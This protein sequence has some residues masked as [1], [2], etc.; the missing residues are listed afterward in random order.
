M[1][2][3]VSR[4]LKRCSEETP[5]ASS[6]C[7]TLKRPKKETLVKSSLTY[8]KVG[9]AILQGKS[10]EALRLITEGSP[11]AW[12]EQDSH[13]I[14]LSICN[15]SNQE[16]IKTL[17]NKTDAHI[18]NI[19]SRGSTP[20]TAAIDEG[21]TEIV[22]LILHRG[23][24]PKL[25]N[26]DKRTPLYHTVLHYPKEAA[27]NNHWKIKKQSPDQIAQTI[28]TIASLLIKHGADVSATE[29]NPTPLHMHVN[30]SN[31]DWIYPK[32][33]SYFIA[34]GADPNEAV[35]TMSTSRT[36]CTSHELG[37][38]I[39]DA[40]QESLEQRKGALDNA[41]EPH[42]GPNCLRRI[43]WDYV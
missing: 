43:V 1:T 38:K 8:S 5:P 26:S 21:N 3:E 27:L 25:R 32:V 19:S 9:L 35:R 10:Q 34:K 16:L 29:D 40:V 17:I 23:A 33:I 6:F 4:P 22:Q 7:H 13:L 20:L 30:Q 14:T 36:M 15:N 24:D 12:I 18:L 41:L 2:M 28:V 11:F 31:E 37:Q 39:A 42:L